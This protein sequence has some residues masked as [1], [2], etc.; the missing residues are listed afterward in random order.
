ALFI[1]HPATSC[2]FTAGWNSQ[3]HWSLS[4]PMALAEQTNRDWSQLQRYSIRPERNGV[5]F[6]G[7]LQTA[8]HTRPFSIGSLTFLSGSPKTL[9]K[10][11][12]LSALTMS[13]AMRLKVAA[14]RMIYV[15]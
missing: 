6:T 12:S 14:R 11:S 3:N 4:L 7:A 9:P 13:Q 2:W 10:L 8:R 5:A 15:V 1:V